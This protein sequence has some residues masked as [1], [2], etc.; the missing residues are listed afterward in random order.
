MGVLIV[1]VNVNGSVWLTND[2][3]IRMT[4]LI[5][6]I[7]TL[8]T[9]MCLVM[10][11]N[12]IVMDDM[13]MRC[14]NCILNLIAFSFFFIELPRIDKGPVSDLWV[15]GSG[16][17]FDWGY[18]KEFRIFIPFWRIIMLISVLLCVCMCYKISVLFCDVLKFWCEIL[19]TKKYFLSLLWCVLLFATI[20]YLQFVQKFNPKFNYEKC[21]KLFELTTQ[22]IEVTLLPDDLPHWNILYLIVSFQTW[23]SVFK[24]YCKLINRLIENSKL[25]KV[26]NISGEIIYHKKWISD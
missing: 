20:R 23:N 11:A 1:M 21:P 18:V 14:N 8:I 15:M 9:T 19:K 16:T 2:F 7:V 3:Y 17:K 10:A 22:R 6:V 12:V 25:I 4:W 13:N 26:R 24:V 5:V